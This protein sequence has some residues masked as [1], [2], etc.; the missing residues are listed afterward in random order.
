MLVAQAIKTR[1]V[2]AS[3][4]FWAVGLYGLGCRVGLSGFL[5]SFFSCSARVARGLV[6][7]KEVFRFRSARSI[8]LHV[9]MLLPQN[10]ALLASAV[11]DLQER[12]L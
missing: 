9:T 12:T 11:K 7:Q 8:M 6:W 4:R 3:F 1:G 2:R 10:A 5:L